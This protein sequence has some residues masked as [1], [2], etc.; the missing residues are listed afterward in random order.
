MNYIGSFFFNHRYLKTISCCIFSKKM[1][2]LWWSPERSSI[3]SWFLLSAI[4]M[5]QWKYETAS[6]LNLF[7]L[8]PRE[9]ITFRCFLLKL[10][11]ISNSTQNNSQL[12]LKNRIR[13]SNSWSNLRFKF[14]FDQI[15]CSNIA[16]QAWICSNSI[17][18]VQKFQK[19]RFLANKSQNLI[20]K[21]LCWFEIQQFLTYYIL[22]WPK[23]GPQKVKFGQIWSNY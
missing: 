2:L 13:N 15:R 5:S 11:R 12:D 23:I 22:I 4:K 17:L 14:K 10:G 21:L 6:R 19:W 18:K 9:S 3:L 16:T 1:L 8:T 20:K 7:L